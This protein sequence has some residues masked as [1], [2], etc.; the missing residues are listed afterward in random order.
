MKQIGL[1]M[2]SLGAWKLEVKEEVQKKGRWSTRNEEES[3][4]RLLLKR[5]GKQRDRE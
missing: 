2:F 3:L 4:F 1:A 5:N